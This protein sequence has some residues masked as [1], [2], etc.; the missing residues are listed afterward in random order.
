MIKTL[1]QADCLH[2]YALQLLN[3]F[4]SQLEIGMLGSALRRS[5]NISCTAMVKDVSGSMLKI[6][7]EVQV[8]FAVTGA[9]RTVALGFAAAMLPA[10]W[11][12]APTPLLHVVAIVTS[13]C[14]KLVCAASI[15]GEKI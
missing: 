7:E 11:K 8:T 4:T 2:G 15:A 1:D 12:C 10:P 6:H 13:A 5:I 14:S 9:V 3:V